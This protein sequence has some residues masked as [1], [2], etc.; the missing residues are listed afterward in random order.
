M[1][2]LPELTTLLKL[3]RRPRADDAAI[4]RAALLADTS[5]Q[6]LAG[7]LRGYARHLGFELDLFEGDFDQ[8]EPLVFDPASALHS[9]RP[10][11]VIVYVAAERTRDKFGTLSI[12]E[13][14]DFAVNFS[15]RVRALHKSLSHSGC[16]TLFFNLADPGDGVFGNYGNKVHWSLQNQI[17]FCNAE[18][19]R[20]AGEADD[21]HVC[22]LSALQSELG[23]GA[24]H[25]PKLYYTSKFALAPGVLPLVAR[26]VVKMLAARKGS[27]VKCVILDLDN[28]LWGGV[29]GD[30]GLE[31]IQIGDLGLG[32]AFSAFQS[33]IK[34]LRD[35]GIVLA[36]CS[37]NDEANA[38]EPFLKHPDM[39]LR[40]EDIAVFMANWDDKAANIRCIKK[41][42][43]VD[44][45]AMMFLDDNPAERQ[46]VRESFPTMQVP[47][48]PADP[49]EYVAY[50]TS[51]NPF[52][53]ASYTAQDAQRTAEYQTEALRHVERE[54]FIN[55]PDFLRSLEMR[56]LAQ[57][58]LP[59]TF[60]RVAQL[61]QRSNQFNLRTVRY[62]EK[63]I[64]ALAA[65]PKHVT[66]TFS[67]KDRFGDNGLISV[68][69]LEILGN[70]FFVDTWLMS[71]RVLG[72]GVE[73]FVLNAIMA[74]ARER[75][76]KRIIG[77]YLPTL[78]NKMVE[79][80]YLKMGFA[81]EADN[82]WTLETDGYLERSTCIIPEETMESRN[83]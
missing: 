30:D 36:V 23:R 40:L 43:D 62:A 59:F 53:T 2:D 21:F 8:I 33:W 44:Y 60:P 46:L 78:K 58:F 26:N 6:L 14:G 49:S 3:A 7:A 74:K 51:L 82:R 22:D 83:P 50:L 32:P 68:V 42:I 54:K 45:G 15:G 25:D 47:E 71:C 80:H 64:A 38:R 66:L 31:R 4:L 24:L 27:F 41:I 79:N 69:I 39:V 16:Q 18:L 75:G 37:K 12:A 67:L 20:L 5:S 29:I 70:E 11:T 65:S 9:F 1:T 28:T 63:E 57:P 34:Q 19:A 52:E 13:R 55:L 77:E 35:R 76:I 48:L 73:E 61:T 72:R 81:V 56:M 10:E 17:R